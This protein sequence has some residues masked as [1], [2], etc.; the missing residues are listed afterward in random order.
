LSCDFLSATYS[1]TKAFPTLISLFLKDITKNKICL[2]K[3]IKLIRIIENNRFYEKD[4][5][6]QLS[7]KLDEIN[8][9]CGTSFTP[10]IINGIDI[11][12]AFDIILTNTKIK[13]SF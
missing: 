10:E 3:N 12:N 6:T 8:N 13:S 9:Y 2:D 1:L 7:S 4:I 5:K 11:S